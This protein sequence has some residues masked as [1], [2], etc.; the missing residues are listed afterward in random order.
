MTDNNVPHAI[1][2]E[3]DAMDQIHSDHQGQGI[4]WPHM[5]LMHML[6]KK[7]IIY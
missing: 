6:R 1:R 4:L 2:E 7:Q 3:V 5:Y